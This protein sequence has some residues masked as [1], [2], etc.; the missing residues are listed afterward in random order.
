MSI[1]RRRIRLRHLW[2]RWFGK[3]WRLRYPRRLARI[4]SQPNNWIVRE[5][6]SHK[7]ARREET[8]SWRIPSHLRTSKL[9][10]LNLMT[11]FQNLQLCNDLGQSPKGSRQLRRF[12]GMSQVVRQR[13]KR[14]NAWRWIGTQFKGFG[15]VLNKKK[16]V[17]TIR[18]F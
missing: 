17:F 4:E 2:L 7:E 1:Y 8:D 10:K 16:K 15:W 5:N 6:G 18:I 9:M 11:Q 14:H 12:L 13:R 3:N